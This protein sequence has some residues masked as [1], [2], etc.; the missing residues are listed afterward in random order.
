[1]GIGGWNR[2]ASIKC[3]IFQLFVELS[4]SHGEFYKVYSGLLEQRHLLHLQ[5]FLSPEAPCFCLPL[6]WR[7][8]S[9]RVS[10][11]AEEQTILDTEKITILLIF[12]FF[13]FSLEISLNFTLSLVERQHA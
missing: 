12:F 13:F 11:I 4:G 5:C 7:L 1:M 6:V 9:I 2:A 8:G 3:K 10:T